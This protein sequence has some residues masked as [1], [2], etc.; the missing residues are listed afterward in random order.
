[1]SRF[2]FSLI[3]LASFSL[4]ATGCDKLCSHKVERLVTVQNMTNQKVTIHVCTDR[5]SGEKELTLPADMF[6][7]RLSLGVTDVGDVQGGMDSMKSCPDNR[8]QEDV[9]IILGKTNFNQYRFCYDSTHLKHILMDLH[10]SCPSGYQEQMTT[11]TCLA[12]VQ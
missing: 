8:S 4:W 12:A 10:Q 7:N 5:L 1:M 11:S 9:G 2:K 3:W 6:E